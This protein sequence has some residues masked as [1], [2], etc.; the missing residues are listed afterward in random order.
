M[1]KEAENTI[2]LIL[3]VWFGYGISAI[4]KPSLNFGV[5]LM[6][7]SIVGLVLLGKF[8]YIKE[9]ENPE[10]QISEKMLDEVLSS[11]NKGLVDKLN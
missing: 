6:L 5:L 7:I 9:S 1:N 2:A 11:I 4:F 10:A 8:N 3:L